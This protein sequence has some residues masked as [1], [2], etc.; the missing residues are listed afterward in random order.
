MNIFAVFGQSFFKALFDSSEEDEE[1]G[2]FS[3]TSS[4]MAIFDEG[5]GPEFRPESTGGN[6]VG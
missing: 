4:G 6:K 1:V 3:D 2:L 5:D